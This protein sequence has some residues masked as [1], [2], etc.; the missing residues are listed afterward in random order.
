MN[1]RLILCIVLFVSAYAFAEPLTLPFDQRPEWISKEGIIMAGSWEPLKFRVRRDGSTDYQPTP[2]QIA[3][4]RR[5]HSPAM[6]K[7]LKKMGINFIM[8]H[9]YK[10]LGLQAEQTSMDDAIRFAKLSHDAGLHVGVY[11]YSGAFLWDQFFQEIPEAQNWIVRN[12]D[13]NPIRYGQASYRYYWNRNHPDAQIFYKNIVRFAVN[14][15]HADL[16]HFDNYAIGPGWD[17]NSV[18]RFRAYLHTVFPPEVIQRMG[19]QNLD[20][21]IPP[22]DDSGNELLRYAWK[23]FC[24]QSLADSYRNMSCYARNLRPTIL[25]ECNPGGIRNSIQPPIDHGRLLEGGEAFWDEG[26]PPGFQDDHLQSRIR[27]YKVARRMN[28]MAFAYCTT[29]L[30]MAESMAFN[31]DCLGCIVWFEYGTVVAKP[32]ST[33][34]FSNKLAPYIQFYK[35]RRNLFDG[36]QVVADAAVLRSFAS[37]VFAKRTYSQMTDSIE[38]A[39]IENRIPFQIIFDQ[40]LNDLARYKLLVLAGCLALSE[41]QVQQIKKYLESGGKVCA[42]GPAAI[43]DEW[44]NP[45]E[46]PAFGDIPEKSFLHIYEKDHV[47]ELIK[48]NYSD[49][50]S[51]QID[52]A[53]GLCAELTDGKNQRFIHLVNYRKNNPIENVSIRV[54]V[55]EGKYIDKVTLICPTRMEDVRLHYKME[56]DDILLTIPKVET[57]EV[58]MLDYK[59]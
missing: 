13:G 14:D 43:Y 10:G 41:S 59:K 42:I 52:A 12:Q 4:Y 27:T 19:I 3:A 21:V 37:Q 26:R 20:D 16:L 6:I 55:P 7:Q 9:C 5:E 31:Q 29:P 11:N 58:V 17:P 30:E 24:C 34:P 44:M 56:G 2:E 1:F 40:Q 23:D 22:A 48:D 57:Y 8:M 53:D 39:F 33:E 46:K 15:I 45:R 50:F 35:S 18:E 47:F 25:V 28:N 51:I 54:R 32:G 49:L 38:Q 36:T